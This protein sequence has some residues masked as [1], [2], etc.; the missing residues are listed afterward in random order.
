MSPPVQMLCD[1]REGDFMLCLSPQGSLSSTV[2]LIEKFQCLFS[3]LS[4]VKISNRFERVH[5]GNN[6]QVNIP[7]CLCICTGMK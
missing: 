7:T 1:V 4:L 5:E 3:L 6:K 2:L